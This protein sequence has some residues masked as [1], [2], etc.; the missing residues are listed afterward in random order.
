MI[1]EIV[2]NDE[3]KKSDVEIKTFES[4]EG[5]KYP[6]EHEKG[7]I[8]ILHDLHER[9]K[10]DP[11]VQA[12]T[13]HSRHNKFSIIKISQ[14]YYELPKRSIR[15][16]GNIYH[17]FKPNNYRDVQNLYRDKASIVMTFSEYKNLTKICWDKEYQP[18]TIDISKEKYTGRN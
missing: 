17:I 7:G 2:K 11:R 10:I 6:Q 15:G 9:E 5:L 18:L 3:F 13:K 1:D 14:D 4:I 16:N 8:Y 12:L